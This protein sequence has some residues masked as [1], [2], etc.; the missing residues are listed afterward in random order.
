MS[1][2]LNVNG[3]EE[4]KEVVERR[5]LLL[6]FRLWLGKRWNSADVVGNFGVDGAEL[7]ESKELWL[8]CVEK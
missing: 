5:V 8:D 1:T 7:A 3:E 2:D 6:F 4:S